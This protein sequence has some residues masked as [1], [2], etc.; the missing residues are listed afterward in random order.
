ML[1][2]SGWGI[3]LNTSQLSFLCMKAS[4]STTRQEYPYSLSY[5]WNIRCVNNAMKLTN[6]TIIIDMDSIG[7]P[8][9]KYYQNQMAL[10]P[11]DL[12]KCYLLF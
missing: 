12:K 1:G 8:L 11:I 2:G 6:L 7:Y 4:R 3:F 5:L 9:S 10:H